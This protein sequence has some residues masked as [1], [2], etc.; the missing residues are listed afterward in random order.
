MGS[1]KL[2]SSDE[3]KTLE[4]RIREFVDSSNDS[5]Y[6]NSYSA[7][8]QA[9]ELISTGREK[10]AENRKNNLEGF[11]SPIEF[12]HWWLSAWNIQKGCCIYCESKFADID[13]AIKSGKLNTRAINGGVRGPFPEIER[14]NGFKCSNVYSA[15]NCALICYYCNNDKSNVYNNEDY[16][17][18]IAPAKKQYLDHLLSIV[19]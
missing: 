13:K 5:E 18:F 9:S 17:K 14:L 11:A 19:S 12:F 8:F 4:I 3:I 16:K 7:K 15:S 10:I 6:L 2:V 1:K